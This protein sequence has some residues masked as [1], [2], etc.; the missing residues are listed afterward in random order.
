MQNAHHPDLRS[1]HLRIT[2]PSPWVRRFAPLITPG[3]ANE[4]DNGGAVLD[5]AAGGGAMGRFTAISRL[6]AVHG[7]IA[8][9]LEE[10]GIT[11]LA[12]H[13]DSLDTASLIDIFRAEENSCI[14]GTDAIR[15]GGFPPLLL[16]PIDFGSLYMQQAQQM[17]ATAGEPAG[18]A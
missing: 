16:D 11:L 10:A 3:D 6:R 17:Q 1:R 18:H 4:G 13:V 2:E 7:L 8:P 12:Q 14:L 15:D 5:L 9:A